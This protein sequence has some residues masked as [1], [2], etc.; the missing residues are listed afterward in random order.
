MPGNAHAKRTN[1][2]KSGVS[3]VGLEYS[4]LAAGKLFRGQGEPARG[5]GMSGQDC[6]DRQDQQVFF[7]KELGDRRKETGGPDGRLL[8]HRDF[9]IHALTG[10]G[11]GQDGQG[12]CCWPSWT[13]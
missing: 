5:A 8:S 9:G 2:F 7:G 1:P 10:V 11:E 6:Q 3:P 13:G 12:I 4:R